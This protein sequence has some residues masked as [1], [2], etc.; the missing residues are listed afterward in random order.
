MSPTSR[1]PDSWG[2]R[3]RRWAPRRADLTADLAVGLTGAVGSV[4]DGMAASALAGVGPQYGLYAS[5]AGPILGGL[6]SSTVLLRIT[7]TSAAALAAGELFSGVPDG[8]R[9]PTLVTL[10]VLTG[11]A[12]IVAGWLRLGRFVRFVSHSV[13]VGFLTGVS[14]LVALGQLSNVTG[15][16]THGPNAVVKAWNVVTNLGD[17]DPATILVAVLAAGFSLA[18]M[19]TPFASFG[20]LATLVVSAAVVGVFDLDSVATVGN[21]P[22]GIPAPQLPQL[23]VLTV[24]MVTAA[25]AIAV[26]VAVQGAGVAAA[27]PNPDGTP[28]R[29]SRDFRAQGIANIGSGLFTGLAVGA[30]VGQTALNLQSGA[31]SRWAAVFSGVWMVA[32]LL[33]LSPAVEKVP[34][35]SLGALLIVAGLRA[36]DALE[37]RSIWSTARSSRVVVA[38][39]LITTS[40]L[41]IQVAVAIGVAL[42]AL[43]TLYEES[44][45]VRLSEHVLLPGGRIEERDPPARLRDR[46]VT[47]LSVDGSVFYAGARVVAD[48]FPSAEG[49]DRPVVVLRLRSQ[50]RVGSTFVDVLALYAAS[51]ASA[52]GRL[53][54]TGVSPDVLS[55]LRASGKLDLGETTFAEVA[56]PIIGESTHL[57]V[58]DAQAWLASAG[59]EAGGRSD[60]DE[61]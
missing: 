41:P 22:A 19:R 32:F 39:T 28:S 31:R 53:Y 46:A 40:L 35:A 36:V 21:I 27:T 25:A 4:P 29:L 48:R 5:F 11:V 47:I 42:S 14:L 58:A 54:L 52:G 15:V 13:M 18:A 3:L 7:T 43:L 49:V 2:A 37:L 6:T 56:E 61:A 57:A 60:P 12:L 38:T 34:T 44:I 10:V 24:D 26:I 20:P 17:A 59:R 30:S 51:I 1:P 8:E 9:I 16:A 45:D 55:R 23:S 50:R 33:L